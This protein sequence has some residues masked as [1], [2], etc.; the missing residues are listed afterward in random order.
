MIPARCDVLVLGGGPAGLAA[1]IH[2]RAASDAVVVVADAGDGGRE[3]VGETVPP[4]IAIPLRRL[5]LTARFAASGHLPCPGSV[6]AWG[7]AQ[8]G[9]NDFILNP[10]GHGWHLHRRRFEQL[11]ADRAGE[12]GATVARPA[13]FVC[14]M[15]IADGHEVQLD[16]DRGGHRI[17]ARWVIDATGVNARFAREQGARRRV[18]D[19][20]VATAHFA[21]MRGG[22]L[23][24]QTLLEATEQGWWYAAR[25]PGDRVLTMLVTEPG[26]VK[27]LAADHFA[28]WKSQL[29]ATQL[30]APRLAAVKLESEAFSH[31]PIWSSLLEPL[32]GDRWLAIGDAAAC[33]D[34][35]S[36]QGIFK[37]MNDA[38][39]A[40]VHILAALGAAEAPSWHRAE[41]LRARF[42]D[43]LRNRAYLYAREQRWP[44]APFWARRAS[45]SAIEPRVGRN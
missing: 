30:L 6:S 21:K 13:R 5:G 24:L 25:L 44:D 1:A 39:D 40:A 41:C 15:K 43:Y 18:Q 17:R 32:E 35:L 10:L 7:G 22:S 9:F 38:S 37:A 16:G 11:L 20:L 26:E 29:A 4:D 45:T 2:L 3:R 31:V 14:A 19:R 34:P 42:D 23:T 8:P 28:T 36:S 12:L 33:Y 27:T